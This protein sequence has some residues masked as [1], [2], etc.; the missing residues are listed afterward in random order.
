MGRY[1]YEIYG[2]ILE[3]DFQIRP[4]THVP[5]ENDGR[6]VI[7]VSEGDVEDEVMR[8]LREAGAI[9]RKYEIGTPVSAFFNRCGYYLIRDGREIIVKI[10]EGYDYETISPWILGFSVSMAL[11]QR[12]V[13]NIHCSAVVFDDKAVLISGTPG[14][15][16]SSVARRL[17]E[18]GYRLMADDVAA[19]RIVG[20]DCMIYPAF[21][22][23]KL[24][25]NEVKARGLNLE[26]L[27][28]INEDKDKYLVPVK[29]IFE[30]SPKKLAYFFYIVK[31]PVEKLRFEK[32]TGFD[33]FLTIRN[34]LFLHR[35]TGSWE[36]DPEVIN[37]CM[38]IA[39]KCSIYIIVRPEDQDTLEE[40]RGKVVETMN[41]QL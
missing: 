4:L 3:S 29:D 31:A 24:C 14:A 22:F 26:E 16:K 8:I 1:R 37:L 35:L 40:I 41:K 10:R 34:N 12:K 6:E 5:G 21:P 33:C 27:I 18:S 39:S 19:A 15:G 11:L 20:N 32:L 23:Q 25:S 13:M 36:T 28:Y 7:T 17:I 2:I 9:E 30:A 38:A